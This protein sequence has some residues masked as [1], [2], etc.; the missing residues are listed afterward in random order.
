[1]DK[2]GP[3][4]K[5]APVTAEVFVDS[6][7]EQIRRSFVC[8]AMCELFPQI[9]QNPSYKVF[10]RSWAISHCFS[11][12][13]PTLFFPAKEGIPHPQVV[14]GLDLNDFEGLNEGAAK[15]DRR[16]D[17]AIKR[18][19]AKNRYFTSCPQL[20]KWIL[21]SQDLKTMHLLPMALSSF[22]FIGESTP[23]REEEWKCAIELLLYISDPELY[24]SSD[25]L[26]TF[27]EQHY[28]D[29]LLMV[30]LVHCAQMHTN[31][32]YEQ[33]VESEKEEG[34]Q[35]V[36]IDE[37]VSDLR[38][39]LDALKRQNAELKTSMT[40]VKMKAAE[41]EKKHRRELLSRDA[42]NRALNKLLQSEEDSGQERTVIE[43]ENSSFTS[44]NDTQPLFEDQDLLELPES[45]VLF[46]GGHKNIH[47]AM[48]NYFP[49]W[50]YITVDD[51][52][53]SIPK[54]CKVVFCWYNH[55]THSAY[56]RL[57]DNLDKS[58][59]ICYVTATNPDRLIREMRELYTS[60]KM[61]EKE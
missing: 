37:I 38:N 11:S 27:L 59:P 15:Q 2:A 52:T 32:C 41:Q 19:K 13:I 47:K 28:A 12:G 61:K 46:V 26:V 9:A 20:L 7:S 23:I 5:V 16:M 4:N 18:L 14:E 49:N 39:E 50:Q 54:T 25:F 53:F 29:L 30:L 1:M 3:Q 60:E 42:E 31:Q 21:Q 40:E 24:H 33:Y 57:K 17:H 56:H 34:E 36:S 48:T 6:Y 45:R 58:I 35:E 10:G 43:N 55:I 8:G 22:Y 44:E 51:T